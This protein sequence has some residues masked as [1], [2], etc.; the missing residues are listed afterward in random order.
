MSA[1]PDRRVTR[2]GGGDPE[3]SITR[4]RHR[5]AGGRAARDQ[6]SRAARASCRRRIALTLL[7]ALVFGG[8]QLAAACA[9]AVAPA[10]RPPA[11]VSPIAAAATAAGGSAA[12]ELV[13]PSSQRC[14]V[15]DIACGPWLRPPYREY[16]LPGSWSVRGYTDTIAAL[17]HSRRGHYPAWRIHL[18]RLSTG[19]VSPVLTRPLNAR[20]RYEIANVAVS[21]GW[22]VW[23]EVGPGDDLVVPVAWKLYAA[24]IHEGDLSIG[25][26]Y[27]VA[28]G[29]TA[30]VSRPLIDLEGDRLMW[31]VNAADPA[32]GVAPRG[33]WRVVDLKRGQL[34]FAWR[35]SPGQVLSTP[36]LQ[37]DRAWVQVLGRRIPHGPR[38]A[39]FRL[40]SATPLELSL[41]LNADY[42]INHWPAV[43]NGSVAW[44]E[45][46]GANDPYPVL[47]LRMPAGTVQTIDD[48]SSEPTFVGRYLFYERE[49]PG[50]AK[51]PGETSEIWAYDTK[52]RLRRPLVLA[53][54]QRDGQWLLGV[55]NSL[56][57]HTLVVWGDLWATTTPEQSYVKVRVYRLRE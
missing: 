20:L 35:A 1:S 40:S 17:S 55:N 43:R 26:P 7:A 47:F 27:L 53:E 57:R 28:S 22:L 36:S 51:R 18:M 50:T 25:R 48:Y 23:E 45:F 34:L 56:S 38:I 31:I 24:A 37:D 29:H 16:R 4:H 11:A 44:S 15:G 54:L 10:D 41:D 6:G 2:L 46:Q 5:R 21:D 8:A 52:G 13:A 3:A 30:T 9:G 39:V 49:S 14:A 19:E 12:V 42:G 32:N 33:E